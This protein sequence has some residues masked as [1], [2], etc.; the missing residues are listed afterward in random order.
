MS[1]TPMATIPDETPLPLGTSIRFAGWGTEA[2]VMVIQE[3]LDVFERAHPGVAVQVRLDNAWAGSG[4]RPA[5]Q[6]G[7]EADVVRVAADDVFDLTAGG[8]LASLDD[9]V[10]RDLDASDLAP[11]VTK[12]RPGPGGEVSALS[13]ASAYMGLFYNVSHMETAGL[14]PPLSWEDPWTV[15]EFEEAARRLVVSDFGRVDRFG[16]SA[17][18]SMTRAALADSNGSGSEDAFFSQDQTR[19]TMHS[20]IHAR[21]LR[22]MAAWRA[23]SAFELGINERAAGPFNSGLVALYIDSSDFMPLIRPSV[24]WGFA[25]LPSWSSGPSRSEGTE[26]CIA[27]NSTSKDVDSAWQLTKHFLEAEVQRAFARNGVAVPFR[28]SVLKDPAF[29]DPNRLPIDR[30]QLSGAI[31]RDIRTPSNPGSKAWHALTAAPIDAVRSGATDAD[32]FLHTADEVIT[33]QLE[34]HAWSAEKDIPGY[35]RPLPIGNQLAR[36]FD[37]RVKAE[38]AARSTPMSGR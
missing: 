28:Q 20:D 8:Y 12:A 10:A 15:S 23:G 24:R 7:I 21:V 11:G 19:S 31:A 4:M 18:P 3:A 14:E 27:V 37:G 32:R 17:V 5:L 30:S 1:A 2:D 34:A 33:R 38:P 13:V 29:L 22:R 6:D 35:R 26:F 9:L 25:P 16:L 36:E